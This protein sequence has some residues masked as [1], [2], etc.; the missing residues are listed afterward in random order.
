M[1]FSN[2]TIY[3]KCTQ[4]KRIITAYYVWLETERSAYVTSKRCIEC[5]GKT[6]IISI[7]GKIP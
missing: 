4:C 6:D 5:G 1:M 2:A 3:H 7:K